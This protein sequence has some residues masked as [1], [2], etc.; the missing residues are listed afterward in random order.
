MQP[1]MEKRQVTLIL[2]KGHYEISNLKAYGGNLESLQAN[3]KKLYQNPLEQVSIED[4]QLTGKVET[5]RAGYLIT[6]L[7]FDK[8]FRVYVDGKEVQ[9]EKVNTAFLGAQVPKGN[10]TITIAY[11]APGKT[12]GLLLTG[13]GGF[14]LFLDKVKI[15]R[16]SRKKK[17]GMRRNVQKAA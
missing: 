6:S 17:N 9:T 2:G 11:R 10:H 7:P 15:K 12:A 8:H 3:S 1:D 16:R 5:S 13:G 14:L 4:N